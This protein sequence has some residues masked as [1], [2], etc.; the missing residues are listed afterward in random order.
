MTSAEW[1]QLDELRSKYL[2]TWLLEDASAPTTICILHGLGEHGGRYQRLA[3]DLAAE[4]FRVLAMDQQGHGL[5]PEKRGCIESYDS[6]LQDVQALLRWS[7]QKHGGPHVLFGHSMGGNLSLN[8]ALR[9]YDQPEATISSSPMIRAV[10]QPAGWFVTLGRMLM[11]LWPNF[12]LRSH[13]IAARLMSDPKEQEEFEQ[14]ELFH[15]YL[16]LRLGNEL[17]KTGEWALENAARLRKPLL[18]TH[19]SEDVLTCPKASQEFADRAN[20]WCTFHLFPNSLHDPFRCLERKEVIQYFV[21]Y[22]RS[23]VSTSNSSSSTVGGEA[24]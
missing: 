16:S 6:V 13:T 4:G 23:T 2:H 11:R 5:S 18:L 21:N 8:Y 17:L 7:R 12:Q 22:L 24:V 9:D 1:T 10:R 19:S 14:D 15:N 3:E 20:E